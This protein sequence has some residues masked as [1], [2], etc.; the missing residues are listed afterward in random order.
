MF[1]K[2]CS[3]TK[4]SLAPFHTASFLRLPSLSN[5][6]GL[7]LPSS[8]LGTRSVTP[9]SGPSPRAR[10]SPARGDLPGRHAQPRGQSPTAPARSPRARHSRA[11]RTAWEAGVRGCGHGHCQGWQALTRRAGR[12]GGE[13]RVVRTQASHRTPLAGAGEKAGRWPLPHAPALL[14]TEPSAGKKAW[15]WLPG[16]YTCQDGPCPL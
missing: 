6:P 9:V 1:S 14:G 4:I 7:P 3:F 16:C 2:S 12:R 10:Q 11:R 5:G 8:A 13:R 15:R